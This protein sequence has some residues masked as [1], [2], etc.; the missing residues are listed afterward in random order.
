MKDLLKRNHIVICTAWHGLKKRRHLRLP[1]LIDFTIFHR[2]TAFLKVIGF[3]VTNQQ[4][5]RPEEER[6]IAPASLA[7]SIQHL[8]PDA[9]VALSV[10]VEPFRTNLQ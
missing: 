1:S 10:F 4:A 5:V 8:G 2:S 6:V 9:S 3:K 7:Q